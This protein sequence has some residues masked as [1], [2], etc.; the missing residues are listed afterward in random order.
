MIKSPSSEH[1]SPE[2]QILLITP[3]PVNTYQRGAD[4]ASRVPPLALDREFDITKAYADA[5]KDVGQSEGVLVLDVWTA[6]FEAAGRDEKQLENF[7]EDGLHL[8]AA[9]YT[10]SE[11][12]HL[13]N[14]L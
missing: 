1:Y 10:A 4:L 6:I 8:N 7:L 13:N 14:F 5:V 9:G 12:Y 3:P 11:L 2:T